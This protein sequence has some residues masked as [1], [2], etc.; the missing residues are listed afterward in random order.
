MAGEFILPPTGNEM[1]DSLRGLQLVADQID[2][3]DRKIAHIKT[4]IGVI[5]AG[6][7]IGKQMV[8]AATIFA[9]DS[10]RA[11]D[12]RILLGKACYS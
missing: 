9:Q 4:A 12:E 5:A 8:E 1:I 7:L 10:D 3:P 6:Q 11:P 2:D